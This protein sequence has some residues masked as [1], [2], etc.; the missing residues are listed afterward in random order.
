MITLIAA[1]A[2]Y[3]QRNRVEFPTA[4]ATVAEEADDPQLIKKLQLL[5]GSV[6]RNEGL[7]GRPVSAI[8]LP[9][10]AVLGINTVTCSLN[11]GA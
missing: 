11:L 5:G 4:S 1:S 10:A 9:V 7:P 6:E 2:C 8:S 3:G